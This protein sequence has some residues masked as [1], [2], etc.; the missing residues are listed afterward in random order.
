M[1]LNDVDSQ[2]Q[3]PWHCWCRKCQ[4]KERL[5]DG[6]IMKDFLCL[7][8]KI[9]LVVKKHEECDTD[10]LKKKMALTTVL[11]GMGYIDRV[12][13]ENEEEWRSKTI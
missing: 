10:I 2:L 11:N 12:R 8:K 3:V 4:W 13:E 1:K 9:L 6:Q 7:T 5:K